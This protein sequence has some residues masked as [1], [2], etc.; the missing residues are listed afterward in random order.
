MSVAQDAFEEQSRTFISLLAGLTT[1]IEFANPGGVSLM[2]DAFVPDGAGP[3][4]TC[5]LVHAA[6]AGE[7]CGSSPAVALSARYEH[8]DPAD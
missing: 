3:F 7:G 5:I 8:A 1:D 2:R 4:A 6:S